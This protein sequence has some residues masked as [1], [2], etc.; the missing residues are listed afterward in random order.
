MSHFH[1]TLPSDS[2]LDTYPGNTTSRYTIKL[3]ERLELDGD[4]EVG[5]AE[6]IYPHT[7]FNFN[8]SDGKY[9]INIIKNQREAIKYVFKSGYY[10]DGTAFATSLN[11]QL[12]RATLE[13]ANVR[14]R[15]TFNPTTLRI[16]I[17][18]SSRNW[19]ILSNEFMK[20]LGFT[21]GWL[22]KNQII[23]NDMLDLNSG[24][25]LMYVYCDAASFSVVGDVETPLLRVCNLSGSDGETIRT[26]FT[27]P[28]YV[29]VA[30]R[31]LETIEINIS[32]ELGRPIPFMHGKVLAT[33]HF[34][35][36]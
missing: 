15:F 2:S 19:V 36:R 3:S 9:F 29:S 31:E 23:A 21:R 18:N 10:A 6:L 25:N 27:H 11:Q 1:V 16:T 13:I 7:W 33:L 24:M 35:S 22:S 4:Y 32:D 17:D 14:L 5:L 8:N 34:R 30:R 12:A 28:H 20:F 26:I